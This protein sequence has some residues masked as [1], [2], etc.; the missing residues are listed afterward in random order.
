MCGESCEKTELEMRGRAQRVDR[1]G[2][3]R[4]HIS[5]VTA[6]NFTKFSSDVT[7]ALTRASML[8]SSHTLWNAS[9]Q[10]EGGYTNF[11]RFA[12]KIRYHNNV[13]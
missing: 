2:Q 8:R 13:P 4:L 1:L 10:N 6:P 3:T 7:A 5:G 12:P 9:A 11:H